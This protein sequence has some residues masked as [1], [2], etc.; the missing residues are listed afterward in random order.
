MTPL[1]DARWM[2]RALRLAARGRGHV[3]PNPMVGAV[4]VKR[5]RVV[6]EGYHREVGG[7]HAEVHALRDAG[8]KARGATVYLTLE[9]CCH[10]GRTPPC[11]EALIA[12]GV[13][14][15]VAAVGDPD[16]RVSGQGVKV[17]R[18]AGIEVEVGVLE[19]DAWR[20]NEAYFKRVTT[21]LPFVSLKAAMSL[22]GKIASATGESKWI[23]GEKARALGHRLRAEHDAVLTGVETVLADDPEL[24]V[25]LARGRDPLR[26]VADSRARTPATARV[27]PA[28]IAVTDR[29]PA[30]RVNAL[31][32]AGAEVWTLPAREGEVRAGSAEPALSLPKGVSPARVDLEALLRRL[33]ER[34]VQSVLLEAGGTLAAAALAADLV[35]R[36]YLFVAP[37]LLGGAQ[38]RTPIEG[39][40]A[41]RLEDCWRVKNLRTRRVGEEVLITGD[42]RT[43]SNTETRR[44]RR[45]GPKCSLA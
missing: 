38:A 29:A 2:R 16:P 10:H 25:R 7:P 43:A 13:A 44:T 26:V 27:L 30:K 40:G 15:V 32:A 20:L 28:I 39:P 1:D 11:T 22:D 21:G 8:A 34:G 24:T 6:G 14:R 23:T 35:D 4:V 17:L 31:L 37:C 36:L 9:P 3:S 45:T 5:G 42:L 33:A 19:S 18:K 12:A 41:P